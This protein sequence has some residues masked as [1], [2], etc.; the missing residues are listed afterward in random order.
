[1]SLAQHAL[2]SAERL[3][4]APLHDLF[5]EL[6]VE[7]VEPDIADDGFFGAV[8]VLRDGGIV[9][10]MPT[11]RPRVER[12]VIARG[13]LGNALRVPLPPLPDSLMATQL[14]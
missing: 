2:P 11:G 6:D 12:D 14:V 10:S 1:M 13:L 8:F 5:E 4:T 7:L 3:L 9:L